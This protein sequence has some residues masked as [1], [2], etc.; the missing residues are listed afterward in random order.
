[1]SND[2]DLAG[3]YRLL[4]HSFKKAALLREALTHPSLGGGA[5][6]QRLEFLGDRVLGIVIAD[7]LYQ[8][9][10]NL[11]EGDL[12]RR[13][14]DLVRRET[15]AEVCRAEK[16]ESHILMAKSAEDDGGRN[17]PAIQADVC[18]AVIGALYVDGGLSV[19]RRFIE[20]AWAAFLVDN[21]RGNRDA[22]S[23]LQEW[24]QGRG[25]ATPSYMEIERSGPDHAPSFVIEVVVEGWPP[26][27]GEGPSK[28]I[29]E[30]MAAEIMLQH[31]RTER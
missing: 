4:G 29:A 22:K 27:R 8:N 19:A 6:Y 9:Y 21:K 2:G 26:V 25:L 17:K 3:L 18:E 11:R 5:N 30:M 31:V 20:R 1:M 7:L 12:A 10:P 24:A 23:A 15:L 28:R 16:L 14:A 13:F